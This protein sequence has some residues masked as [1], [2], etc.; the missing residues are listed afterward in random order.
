MGLLHDWKLPEGFLYT[1]KTVYPSFLWSPSPSHNSHNL[2]LLSWPQTSQSHPAYPMIP[3]PTDFPSSIKVLSLSRLKELANLEDP[4]L[5]HT[6][7]WIFPFVLLCFSLSQ[8]ICPHRSKMRAFWLQDQL[9][10]DF[11]RSQRSLSL[12]H[13]VH[14]PSST[15]WLELSA[16]LTNSQSPKLLF[17][18]L[19]TACPPCGLGHGRFFLDGIVA[20]CAAWDAAGGGLR[21]TVVW[22][23]QGYRW[24]WECSPLWAHIHILEIPPEQRQ[25]VPC[26]L[27][28]EA[29][30]KLHAANCQYP[31][32]SCLI[33]IITR[34][35]AFHFAKGTLTGSHLKGH[36]NSWF[37]LDGATFLDFWWQEDNL[38][39]A[40]LW[41][42][43]LSQPLNVVPSCLMMR[44]SSSGPQ[45][46]SIRMTLKGNN[47][48]QQHYA[49]RLSSQSA[50]VS[51]AHLDCVHIQW[52]H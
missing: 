17:S 13:K 22:G 16:R 46:P 40:R 23:R 30:S 31:S 29:I 18:G 24:I 12:V 21:D 6:T 47:Q 26:H 4:R 39:F 10:C 15:M 7:L 19:K 1:E 8:L 45:I 43:I 32:N 49:V 27:I 28:E 34:Q 48:P 38:H 14:W 36:D 2:T 35:L 52:G 3:L 11:R 41:T 25:S 50:T 44:G 20:G 9:Y 5:R 51:A 33:K 37:L 42:L